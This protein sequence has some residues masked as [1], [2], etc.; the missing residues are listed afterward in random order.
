MKICRRIPYLFLVSIILMSLLVGCE[1]NNSNSGN[2]SN[3]NNTQSEY[4]QYNLLSFGKIEIDKS[5]GDGYYYIKV[6]IKNNSNKAIRVISPEMSI[7]D[8]SNTLVDSTYPQQQSTIKPKQSFYMDSLV[9]ANEDI[10]HVEINKYSYYIG[11][12]FYDVDTISEVINIS[13]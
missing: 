11:K 3:S 9:E 10:D 7:Y 4:D 6:K 8:K 1:S 13:E 2:S 5:K 12:T